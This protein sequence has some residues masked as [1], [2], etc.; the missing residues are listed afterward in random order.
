MIEYE[1]NKMYG[2]MCEQCTVLK[3]GNDR[4]LEISKIHIKKKIGEILNEKK[5]VDEDTIKKI[6]KEQRKRPAIIITHAGVIRCFLCQ[7]Q[8]IP[9]KDAFS[10]QVNYGSVFKISLDKQKKQFCPPHKN[11]KYVLCG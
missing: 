2:N 10:L 9:L 3:E 5:I 1:E 6:L 7:K 4:N 11:K 8:N